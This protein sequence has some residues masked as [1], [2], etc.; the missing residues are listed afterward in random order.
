MRTIERGIVDLTHPLLSSTPSWDGS[1][2]F[3]LN[4]DVDY[5][6]CNPPYLFRNQKIDMRAGMGTHMDAPAHCF[7]GASTIEKLALENLIVPCVELLDLR[8][9]LTNERSLILIH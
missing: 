3:T 6:D 5:D 7:E 1:C 8:G 4:G 9:R 2:G